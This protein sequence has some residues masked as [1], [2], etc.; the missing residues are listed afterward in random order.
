M[1]RLSL[2]RLS[3]ALAA[4]C[5]LL[6][7][8]LLSLTRWHLDDAIPIR[9]LSLHCLPNNPHHAKDPPPPYT[10]M[11]YSERP[12]AA[13]PPLLSF[14]SPLF[15]FCYCSF[16]SSPFSVMPELFSLLACHILLLSSCLEVSLAVTAWQGRAELL[17]VLLARA[18]CSFGVES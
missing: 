3:P 18:R 15:F 7:E 11:A 8:T 4:F 9:P 13:I 5:F 2:S 12:H 16:P 14:C 1:F 6:V 10:V 17:W